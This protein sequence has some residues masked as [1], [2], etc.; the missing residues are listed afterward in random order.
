MT[1]PFCWRRSLLLCLGSSKERAAASR[2]KNNSET[3]S[4]GLTGVTQLS[5]G[6]GCG[7]NWHIAS[8]GEFVLQP[9]RLAPRPAEPPTPIRSP[10]PMKS[11]AAE[12]KRLLFDVGS[13]NTLHLALEANEGR[14]LRRQEQG[15]GA[16]LGLQGHPQPRCKRKRDW[17]GNLQCQPC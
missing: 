17:T 2:E 3:L 13:E 12:H 11:T 5:G 1:D 7:G 10:N 4:W 16:G 9:P 15:S 6:A 8:H 14:Q